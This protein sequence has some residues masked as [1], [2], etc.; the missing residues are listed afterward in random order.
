V[1]ETVSCRA[2]ATDRQIGA[3]HE[4][5]SS[6]QVWFHHHQIERRRIV[7]QEYIAAD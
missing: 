4:R 7:R 3:D 6:R 1:S 2:Y 5:K